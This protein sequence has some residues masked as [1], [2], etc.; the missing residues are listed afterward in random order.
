MSKERGQFAN[1]QGTGVVMDLLA[2]NPP[3]TTSAEVAGPLWDGF[4]KACGGDLETAVPMLPRVLEMPAVLKMLEETMA[5]KHRIE[6][7]AVGILQ[8][9]QYRPYGQPKVE[10][11]EPPLDPR[12]YMPLSQFFYEHLREKYVLQPTLLLMAHACLK[13]CERYR[14]AHATIMLVSRVLAG[15]LDEATWRYTMHWRLLLQTVPLHSARDFG[16]FCSVLYPGSREE[17]VDDL[18]MAYAAH[19]SE[20]TSAATALEFLT[21]KLLGKQELRYRKWTKILKWKDTQHRNSFRRSDFLEL[22]QKMFPHIRVDVTGAE[23][24]AAAQRY[25]GDRVPLETLAYVLCCLD[26]MNIKDK[27]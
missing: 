27:D 18:C 5:A 26:T 14:K 4:R 22:C 13:G 21:G 24:D 7:K 11:D 9:R 2:K 23:Y 6:R 3:G 8:A 10:E 25:G 1:K 20:P 15:E 17:E 19:S 12:T 16:H